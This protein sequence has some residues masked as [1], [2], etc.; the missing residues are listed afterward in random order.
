MKP[1][2][3]SYTCVFNSCFRTLRWLLVTSPKVHWSKGS[4]VQK[5]TGAN[6]N[7]NCNPIPNP[8]VMFDLWNKEML[9]SLGGLV[10]WWLACRT[11]DPRVAGSTPDR[12]IISHLNSAFHPSG[13]GKSSTS[14]YGWG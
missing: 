10:V 11:C 2:A 13:V 5:V 6:S 9:N 12:R 8:K 3:V 14:L 4:L 7:P 1:T